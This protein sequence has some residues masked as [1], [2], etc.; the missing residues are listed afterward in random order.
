[1]MLMQIVC[2]I[3]TDDPVKVRETLEQWGKEGKYEGATGKVY[4]DAAGDRAYPNYIIWGVAL[5][6]GTPKYVDAAYY[7]GTERRFSIWREELI[8]R[9]LPS[10]VSFPRYIPAKNAVTM[11]GYVIVK[12]VILSDSIVDITIPF[13][14][15]D[16]VLSLNRETSA[17]ADSPVE[18][19]VTHVTLG[20]VEV[21]VRAGSIWCLG[22]RP[23][24][25]WPAWT[26]PSLG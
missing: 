22:V 24:T 8:P 20:G 7:Y 25:C 2:S 12:G 21:P 10:Y 5:E 1:M 19:W 17:H 4:L 11:R 26:S 9:L 13:T 15:L 18:I 6:G 23:P 16:S 3:G 14:T